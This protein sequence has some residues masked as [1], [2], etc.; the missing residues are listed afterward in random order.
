M[1]DWFGRL[2]GDQFM[3]RPPKNPLTLQMPLEEAWRRFAQVS[4]D[5][6]PEVFARP[7]KPKAPKRVRPP[8]AKK[9][10]A[11]ASKAKRTKNTPRKKIAKR[12]K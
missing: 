7:P 4:S 12:S 11:K 6:M 9:P 8:K 1:A 3:A 2:F 5:E 10:S